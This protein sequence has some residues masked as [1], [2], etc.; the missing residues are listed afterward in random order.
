M[1]A[2]LF[3]VLGVVAVP[4][5]H[6]LVTDQYWLRRNR[7]WDKGWS[8]AWECAADHMRAYETRPEAYAAE[9]GY[10]WRAEEE[11]T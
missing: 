1:K 3:F 4:V 10:W 5:V 11:I 7:I 9:H 8:D 2:V 6:R